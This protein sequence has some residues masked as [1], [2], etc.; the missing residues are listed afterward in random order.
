MLIG[1]GV[2]I[3]LF[4]LVILIFVVHTPGSVYAHVPGAHEI[5]VVEENNIREVFI[6]GRNTVI[7][8]V[9]TDRDG[10]ANAAFTLASNLNN[11]SIAFANNTLYIIEGNSTVR[12]D[13]IIRH[14]A[15]PPI[16][17]PTEIIPQ[18]AINGTA[19]VTVTNGELFANSFS[20]AVFFIAKN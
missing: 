18:N 16:P 4:C 14:R 6:A 12:M 13:D 11:P 15:Y 17:K 20:G 9:D 19:R 5:I 1:I 3:F 8:A 10:N 7:D 2:F